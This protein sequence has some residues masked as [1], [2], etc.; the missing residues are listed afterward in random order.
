MFRSV[1]LGA[2]ALLMLGVTARAAPPLEERVLGNA[3]APVRIDEY[4]SQD[5]P[6]CAAFDMETL[7]QLRK[8]YIDTGKAKL[9]MHE[10]PLSETA[11]R[12][13]MLVRCAEPD[14]YFIM[15]DTLF[16]MQRAWVLQTASASLDALKQQARL[17]GMS[18]SAIGACLAN[19]PLEEA[20]MR[21][22]LDSEK[23]ISIEVTPTFV[24]NGD[25]DNRF[26]G[27][28]PFPEFVKKMDE[29]GKK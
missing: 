2:C 26:D 15:V 6:H 24:F 4:F 21:G 17:A 16:R 1:V 9:V 5:C 7:P 3:K 29:L 14:R 23:A 28:A 22:R 25:I 18:D 13:A 20:L 11:L 10:Y 27:A 8:A 19:Q 12:A